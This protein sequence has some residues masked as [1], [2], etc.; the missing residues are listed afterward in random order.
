MK[1]WLVYTTACLLLVISPGPDNLLAIGRGLSQGRLAAVVSGLSSGM[2]IV[3]HVTAASLGLTLLIQTSEL[4]FWAVKLVGG[5]YLL[6]LGIKVLRSRSLITFAP[7]ARQS[8][9][10][11]FLTGFLSAALNPKPGLFVLAFVP[12]FINPSLGSVTL[13]MLVY[14]LWFAL[15]TAIGFALMGI[16]A[17]RLSAYLRHRPRLA[18]G[19]NLGAGLTFI[20][21]GLSIAALSQR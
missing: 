1:I 6:W 20:V 9:R 7:E 10:S 5:A 19:L 13:Q 14:G 21:S 11:I 12:Q 4:A 3:F 18:N 2:G 8:L 16:F 17:T 15:L